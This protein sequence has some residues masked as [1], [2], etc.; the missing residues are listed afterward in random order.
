[1]ACDQRSLLQALQEGASLT[2]QWGLS[3]RADL[4]PDLGPPRS[5]RPEKLQ[6]LL[7]VG[8]LLCLLLTHNKER[9]TVI[10]GRL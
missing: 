7:Q 1:M 6:P 8:S 2:V 9:A 4:K 10:S 3:L 5:L